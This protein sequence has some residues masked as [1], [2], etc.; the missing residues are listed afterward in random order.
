LYIMACTYMH[1]HTH[2]RKVIRQVCC[3]VFRSAELCMIVPLCML[4]SFLLT[5]SL[6]SSFF[7]GRALHGCPV[8]LSALCV[9]GWCQGMH[10]V[11]HQHMPKYMGCKTMNMYEYAGVRNCMAPSRP[12]HNQWF[13]LQYS[14][15]SGH[16]RSH[17]AITMGVK[18]CCLIRIEQW[19][20]MVVT[21]TCL[22]RAGDQLGVG[23]SP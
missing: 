19:S 8:V 2:T 10:A 21:R 5:W 14:S 11:C 7:V 1:T 13:M 20:P 4:C 22:G 18:S 23:A 17:K 16:I 3:L 12:C 9:V 15:H 6:V